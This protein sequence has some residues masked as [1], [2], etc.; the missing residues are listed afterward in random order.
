MRKLLSPVL[1]FVLLNVLIYLIS[2]RHDP[3][4]P[5]TLVSFDSDVQP[6]LNSYC[7]KSGCH[8]A[9]THEAVGGSANHFAGYSAMP[10]GGSKIS[11][12]NILKI[13]VCMQNGKPNN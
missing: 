10:K 9:T 4:T 6:V 2:C 1:A 11:D 5:L 12:C 3:K 8:D 13:Q 7:A